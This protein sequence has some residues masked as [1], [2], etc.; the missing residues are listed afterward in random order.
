MLKFPWGEDEYPRKAGRPSGRRL[1]GPRTQ[2]QYSELVV[3]E[4]V[5]AALCGAEK[6]RLMPARAGSVLRLRVGTES[7]T[8]P[9]DHSEVTRSGPQA[10]RETARF[11][12]GY[13]RGRRC[14][15]SAA[16]CLWFP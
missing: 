9:G 4:A 6:H 7:G 3:G 11:G 8:W 10:C 1:G 13:G 16:T 12:G 15:T 2:S 5:V 14:W